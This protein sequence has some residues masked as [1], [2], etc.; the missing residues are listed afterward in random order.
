MYGLE[1]RKELVAIHRKMILQKIYE[2]G[3][4][5]RDSSCKA[6]LVNCVRILNYSPFNVF[7]KEKSFQ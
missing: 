7:T 6:D 5:L 3:I 4:V 2:P 1:Y